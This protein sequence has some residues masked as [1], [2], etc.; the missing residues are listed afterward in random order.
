[1]RK[2]IRKTKRLRKKRRK[3]NMATKTKNGGEVRDDVQITELYGGKIVIKFYEKSHQYWVS[4]DSGKTFKRKTGVTTYIGIMDK[5][6]ALGIW[7]QQITA[8]FLIRVI[9]AGNPITIDLALEAAVQNDVQRDSAA[10]IGKAIHAW[11]EAYI[12][13]KLK[14]K[15]FEK[16][17]A[18]PNFPEAITGVNSFM[19]W[20]DAHKVKFV[21]TERVVYSKKHDFVGQMDFE[22]V[23]DGELCMGDFKSSTGLYSGVRMQTAAYAE[24]DMEEVGKRKYAGRWAVRLSKH[25]EEE[26]Y[27]KEERKK[28]M[29]K[30]IARIQ[31]KDYKEYPVKP[32]QVFEAQFLD[33]DRR[34]MKA[35]FEAFLHTMKL[36]KW[37]NAV[38]AFYNGG[39]LEGSD[40]SK[41]S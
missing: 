17:P 23:V 38:D 3:N 9:E 26:Y 21:S 34:A 4:V 29:K 27:R 30:A 32:Y 37:N 5:S 8:D 7:Q 6:R 13:H 14:Q 40:Y 15:G 35:D 11:C 24:A 41:L 39:T 36:T 1:M 12:R 28:E 10:D 19:G 31:G 25:T 22:A 16:L 33:N 18:V 2:R 20:L